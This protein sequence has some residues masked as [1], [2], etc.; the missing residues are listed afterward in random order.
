MLLIVLA[1]TEPWLGDPVRELV[2]HRSRLAAD[3][4]PEALG[5]YLDQHRIHDELG[6]VRGPRDAFYD[7]IDTSQGA[8]PGA[9]SIVIST[10][11]ATDLDLLTS[12]E[13]IGDDALQL[14]AGSLRA[15]HSLLRAVDSV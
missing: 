15:G 9:L 7:A 6:Q 12:D 5:F 13:Q 8:Y 2:P 3:L 1:A 4:R 10:Q 11:A 14:M